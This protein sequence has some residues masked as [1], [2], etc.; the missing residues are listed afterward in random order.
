M[1]TTISVSSSG[2][3]QH[4]TIII[5]RGINED[6]QRCTSNLQ[7]SRVALVVDSGAADIGRHLTRVLNLSDDVV[8]MLAGG[9]QCKT[10]AAVEQLLSF[11]ARCALDRRS[12]V[13]VVGGGAFSD[14]AGFATAIYMRGIDCLIVPTTLLA[15]VDA[16]IGGKSGINF[17]GI[18]N[19]IGSFRQPRFVIVDIDNLKSLPERDLIS[20]FAEIVKHGAIADTSYFSQVTSKRCTAWSADELV[21]IIQRSCEIKARIVQEDEHEQGPRKKLNFGHTVGHALEAHCLHSEHP[22][23]HGEAIAI[24]MHAAGYISYRLG[25]LPLPVFEQLIAGI[26]SVGLPIRLAHSIATHDLLTLMRLDKKNLRGEIRWC[27]LRSIGDAV[28]DHTA[29]DAIVDEALAR[30]QPA[31]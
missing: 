22:L 3:S 17:A 12:L 19:L 16:S 26:A 14:L 15:Q 4:S 1:S 25:L 11:F 8:L 7:Y 10:L 23:T 20:G 29:P 30:I 21:A 6:L 28:H 24:G 13:V 5:G 18:K 2:I 9:E 27:L 31:D